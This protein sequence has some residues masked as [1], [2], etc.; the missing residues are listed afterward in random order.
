MINADYLNDGTVATI[1]IVRASLKPRS[2]FLTLNHGKCYLILTLETGKVKH[3]N[4]CALP[5][6]RG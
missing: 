2:T 5:M 6:D 1:L 4:A 3:S